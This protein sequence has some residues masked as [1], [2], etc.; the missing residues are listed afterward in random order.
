MQST[1]STSSAAGETRIGSPFRN[2]PPPRSAVNSSR[3]VGSYTAAI[4]IRPS[5]SSASDAQKIGRPCAKF[6]VPS[7]GSKI[8]RG[9]D[10]S[11]GGPEA[12]SSSASTA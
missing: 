5:I 3:R 6:V 7:I 12:P 2:A 9:V 1:E 10:P 4:S 8:H 11:G